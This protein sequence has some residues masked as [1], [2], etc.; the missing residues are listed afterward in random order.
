LAFRAKT[1]RPNA[2]PWYERRTEMHHVIVKSV[3]VGLTILLIAA[4]V[5][6]ALIVTLPLA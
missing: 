1:F 6:F 3:V 5:V 2:L 4:V